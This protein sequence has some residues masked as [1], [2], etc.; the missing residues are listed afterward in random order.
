VHLQDPKCI[1]CV[2]GIIKPFAITNVDIYD[3][4]KPTLKIIQDAFKVYIRRMII[5]YSAR[6][7]SELMI[8]FPL[9]YEVKK[10]IHFWNLSRNMIFYF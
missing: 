1:K 4:E 5:S 3:R 2:N 8:Y 7:K 10:K 9:I 6:V